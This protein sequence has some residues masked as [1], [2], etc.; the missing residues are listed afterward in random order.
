MI[1]AAA[2]TKIVL[3]VAPPPASEQ[4][5]GFATLHGSQTI[6]PEAWDAF[7]EVISGTLEN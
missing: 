7:S 4:Q 3:P 2:A 6:P 1:H 5:E